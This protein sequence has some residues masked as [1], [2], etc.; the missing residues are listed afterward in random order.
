MRIEDFISHSND[1][2]KPPPITLNQMKE[3]LNIKYSAAEMLFL[4]RYLGA[5]IGHKIPAN[6][7]HWRLYIMLRKIVDILMSPRITTVYIEEIRTLVTELNSLYLKFYGKLKPKFHFLT[8]YASALYLFGPCVHFWTMRYESR[9]TDVKANAVA[10]SSSVNL[11]KTIALKQVLQM[12]EI[13]NNIELES[14]VTYKFSSN[15]KKVYINN[16]EYSIGTFIVMNIAEPDI[17]FG[18]IIDIQK[19]VKYEESG[20]STDK[21]K[22]QE[23]VQFTV[24]IYNEFYFDEHYMVY[25]AESKNEF[26]TVDLEDIPTIPPV[27]AFE[28]ESF[29]WIIP[30]YRL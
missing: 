4:T 22:A 12:C 24:K 8:H 10:T 5:I 28:K 21:R 14:H 27:A 30:I 16:T 9:H 23:S 11:L 17:Q 3:K 15:C 29:Q 26:K 18:E 13:F 2:N 1:S 7:E 20:G 25:I 6:N 19:A